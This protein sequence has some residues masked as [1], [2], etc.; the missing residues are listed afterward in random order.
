MTMARMKRASTPEDAETFLIAAFMAAISSS[1]SLAPQP[2]LPQDCFMM[3][4]LA[5]NMVSKSI[6]WFWAGQPAATVPSPVYIL[7]EEDAT[8][9]D[10]AAEV[11]VLVEGAAAVA[12]VEVFA[13]VAWAE[14]LAAEEGVLLELELQPAATQ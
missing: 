8:A 12:T 14:D 9:V 7:Y 5:V 11:D 6:H 3:G 4:M 1:E 13:V 2:L 10:V